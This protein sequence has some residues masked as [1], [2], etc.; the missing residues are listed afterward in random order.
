MKFKDNFSEISLIAEAPVIFYSDE[1]NLVKIIQFE[2]TLPSFKDSML[3]PFV[4]FGLAY[5]NLTSADLKK[6]INS[7]LT[8]TSIWQLLQTTKQNE[9]Q[10]LFSQSIIYLLNKY[11]E[12]FKIE[13][14]IFY[15]GR[16]LIDEELFNRI[17]EILLIASGIKEFNDQQKF[18]QGKP[19]WLIEKEAEIK[20]IKN[21][22]KGQ[23]N[24]ANSCD[25]LTKLLLPLNYELGYSFEELFE[26]NYY[27]IKYLGKYIPRFIRYDIQKRQVFSKKPAKYIT[28]K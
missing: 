8:I 5:C 12:D 19:Q 4:Q 6:I 15:S 11:V 17:T 21:S 1:P 13:D 2:V 27:H 7:T 22:A 16:F 26:M 9:Y 24:T 23:S 28:E 18:Q 14:G 20:R 10:D 25:E 3:D